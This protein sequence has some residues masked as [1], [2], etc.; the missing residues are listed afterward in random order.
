MRRISWVICFFLVACLLSCNDGQQSIQGA[1]RISPQL[2]AK[3]APS[4][5]LFIIAR[6]EGMQFGPPLAVKRL[7]QPFSFPLEF[8]ISAQD[9][10]MPNAQFSG[11]ITV[12][13]RIAQSG[14]AVPASPGD[15]EGAAPAAVEPGKSKVEIN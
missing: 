15:I 2:Q 11:K 14:A 3:I 1:L 9:A 12:S 4:A 6:P 10:M 8:S 5:A 7:A 13:A